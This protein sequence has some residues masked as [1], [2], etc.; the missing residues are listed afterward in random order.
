MLVEGLSIALYVELYTRRS[1]AIK[2]NTSRAQVAGL[3][4]RTTSNVVCLIQ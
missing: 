2:I 3:L 1:F 4:A